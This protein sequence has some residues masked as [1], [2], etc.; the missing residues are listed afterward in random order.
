[1]RRSRGMS[2]F[3]AGLIALALLG[4]GTYLGFAKRLP[5]LLRLF[6]RLAGMNS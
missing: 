5:W 2:P 4:A 6:A 1:M 3:A